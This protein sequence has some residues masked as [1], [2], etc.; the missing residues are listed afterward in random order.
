MNRDIDFVAE[1]RFFDFLGKNPFAADVQ[2]RRIDKPIT[3][4]LDHAQLDVDVPTELHNLLPN[5][6][7]LGDGERAAARADAN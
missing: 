1:Q 7:R 6:G 5:P 3:A 4:G 2:D